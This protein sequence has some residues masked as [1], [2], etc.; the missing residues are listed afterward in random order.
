MA[1]A[2]E[3][4]ELAVAD[5][6]SDVV[7]TPHLRD[8]LVIGILDELTDRVQE[9]RDEL[10]D[11]GIGLELH[12]G[13]ELDEID[14]AELSDSQL[15]GL[16]Q[17]A[18]E[19]APRGWLLYEPP[20]SERGADYLEGAAHLRGRGFGLVIAHPE[21][22][23]LFRTPEGHTSLRM[24]RTAG[25]LTQITAGSLLGRHGE[26]A[27]RAAK[28]WLAEGLVDLVASDAHGP[29]K[30]PTL[31]AARREIERLE[32]EETARR[33]VDEAPAALVA[34]AAVRTPR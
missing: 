9:L 14:A 27:W 4:A 2:V 32:D 3:L 12:V 16:A 1:E 22:S 11:R 33:L 13:G 24:L 34:G 25:A 5:G 28:A 7:V 20:W 23:P 10:E 19:G 18:C 31:T 15:E 21:R 8:V 29:R 17:G 26:G 6:T 30:P